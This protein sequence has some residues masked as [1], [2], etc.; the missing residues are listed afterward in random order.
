MELTSN[1][2]SQFTKNRNTYLQERKA[3]LAA[4]MARIKRSREEKKKKEA[5][6]APKTTST[7][8]RSTPRSQD[9]VSSGVSVQSS[10]AA[11]APDH[12]TQE[13]SDDSEPIRGPPTRSSRLLAK[14]KQ[15]MVPQLASED[16]A[17]KAA[18]YS[19]ANVRSSTSSSAIDTTQAIAGEEYKLKSAHREAIV[20]QDRRGVAPEEED[21]DQANDEEKQYCWC[22]G[23]EDYANLVCCD[24]CY[25][26][27]SS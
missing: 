12:D 5:K 1:V 17:L 8:L 16:G 25:V 27:L 14:A 24:C 26:S 19:E 23:S 4:D 20:A 18:C 7:T 3:E 21:E 15:N 11:S 2:F 9:V 10:F 22:K 13:L 6:Q